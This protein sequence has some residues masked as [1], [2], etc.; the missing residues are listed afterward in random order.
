[1][2]AVEKGYIDGIAGNNNNKGMVMKDKLN[3]T[4]MLTKTQNR[5]VNQSFFHQSQYK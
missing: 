3:Q 5:S 1:M 4:G 2:T